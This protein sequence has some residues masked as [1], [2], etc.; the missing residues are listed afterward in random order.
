MYQTRE[1]VIAA[2][3]REYRSNPACRRMT[4]ARQWVN[5]ALREA[6]HD[7][8]SA[9]E[10][11]EIPESRVERERDKQEA[12]ADALRPVGSPDRASV[13][14]ESEREYNDNEELCRKMGTVHSWVNAALRDAGLAGLSDDEI[15]TIKRKASA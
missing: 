10:A 13:I 11:M 5:G 7:R 1:Q 14:A 15:L 6:N 9:S 12:I 2:S 3:E 8:L 4:T